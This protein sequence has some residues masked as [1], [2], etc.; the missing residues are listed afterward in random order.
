M[1]RNVNYCEALLDLVKAS[2]MVPHWIL[3]REGLDLGYPLWLLRLS[4]ATYKM[5]RVIRIRKVVSG[6][7]VA[8][9]G[10]TAGSGFATTEMRLVMINLVERALKC[11]PPVTP[12]LFVD[13][14]AAEAA[15]PDHWI[16]KELG[17]FIRVITEGFKEYQF[18]LSGTKSFV[19][20]IHRRAWEEDGAAMGRHGHQHYICQEGQ[21]PG[22][23]P[24]SWSQEER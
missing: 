4:L 23:G 18:V 17:G 14:L 12:T 16:E 15:G 21:S 22:S 2:D 19:N 1:G 8:F 5:K 11:H 6:E 24:R 20:G 13:D 10:M 3:I 7:E 9:R